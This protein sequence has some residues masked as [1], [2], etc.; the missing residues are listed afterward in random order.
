MSIIH[1][2]YIECFFSS[3]CWI[4]REKREISYSD[5]VDTPQVASTGGAV[6]EPIPKLYS[7]IYT[8]VLTWFRPKP[9]SN[10]PN[11]NGC[12]LSQFVTNQHY[13]TFGV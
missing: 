1:S 5:F 9:S 3:L 7:P 12:G 2:G 4:N 11:C 10:T 6:S 13:A 8:R